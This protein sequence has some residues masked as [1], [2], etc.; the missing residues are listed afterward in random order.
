[1]V[2]AKI[3]VDGVIAKLVYRTKIPKGIVGSKVQIQY[4]DPLWC[5]LQKTVVFRSTV[6]KDIIDAGEEVEVPIEVVSKEG[7]NLLVGIYG[8]NTDKNIILPTLWVD[9]GKVLSATE[10]SGDSSTDPTL[11]VWAQLSQQYEHLL[12]LELHP[13]KA[14]WNA[15]EDL[16]SHIFNRTHWCEFNQKTATF[17]GNLEG[18]VYID[19]G[20]GLYLVKIT[21]AIITATELIGKRISA[22][23]QGEDPE[24][25]EAEI[26]EEMLED[27][28][29][30]GIPVLCVEDLVWVIGED[31]ETDGMQ[32]SKGTYF[33]CIKESNVPIAYVSAISDLLIAE[34]K[35]HKLDQKY[36]DV[37]WMAKTK[38]GTEPMLDETKLLFHS[39]KSNK[40]T[41]DQRFDFPIYAGEKYL[42]HWD[43]K[44]YECRAVSVMM[45][46]VNYIGNGSIYDKD[47]EDSGEPFCVLSY[48]WR[49]FYATTTIYGNNDAKEHTVG[50]WHSGN[51]PNRIPY[52]YLP[53]VYVLPSDLKQVGVNYIELEKGYEKLRRGSTVFALYNNSLYKVLFIN[54]DLVDSMYYNLCISNGRQI[55]FWDHIQ[56]WTRFGYDGFTISPSVNGS[57][58]TD[59]KYKFTV[60][61]NGNLISTDVSNS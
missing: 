36:L 56:G 58:Q 7:V 8:T 39:S 2:I 51:I 25:Q 49:D 11:P 26:T 10:P 24:I 3:E 22:F 28:S 16:D 9:L 53:S 31:F 29:S 19:A 30:S 5:D 35:I 42:V 21:D 55:L 6:T 60:D 61:E 40:S 47:F 45:P 59:K 13:P 33:I 12:N 34:E 48:V 37:E 18:R 1:M 17:D 32:F 14:D 4:K 23:V 46:L 52:K 27:L 38:V 44:E 57:V 54:C 41:C 15:T 50:L 20:D 43:G